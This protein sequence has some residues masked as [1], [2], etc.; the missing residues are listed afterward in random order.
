MPAA[1]ST[2]G[3]ATVRAVTEAGIALE[4]GRIVRLA[5]IE[6]AR[7]RRSSLPEPR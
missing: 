7:D 6:L 4:D 5:G 1:S 2:I 3:T